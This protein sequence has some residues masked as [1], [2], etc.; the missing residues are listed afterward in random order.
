MTHHKVP[1]ELNVIIEY[2]ANLGISPVFYHKRLVITW[3]KQ[4]TCDVLYLAMALN[5]T[6]GIPIFST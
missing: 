6:F 3:L 1:F 4:L 2:L 5:L